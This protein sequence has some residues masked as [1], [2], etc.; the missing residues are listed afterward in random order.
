GRH[1]GDVAHLRGQV[2]RHEV[3]V[4]GE[5]FPG[6]GNPGH[7]RL[8]PE[9]ALGADLARDAGD[10]RGERVQLIDHRVDGVFDLQ[11]L[12]ADV[13]GDFLAEVA[14][15]NRGGDLRHVTQ[16]HGQVAGEQI[17]VVGQIFPGAGHAG[18]DCLATEFA[19]RPDLAR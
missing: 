12:A 14:F 3:D 7:L 2:A 15:G 17:D 9:L 11:N 10:C 13:D 19:L 8:A 1:L 5:I 4:V 16:L 6:A 18:H